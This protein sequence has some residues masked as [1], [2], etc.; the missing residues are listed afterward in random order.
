[1]VELKKDWNEADFA[2][3][4]KVIR[5]FLK[6]RKFDTNEKNDAFRSIST[7]KQID[8]IIGLAYTSS[9]A[10]TA[11]YVCSVELYLDADH[12]YKIRGFVIGTDGY[13]YAF[14]E[15]E[16]DNELYLMI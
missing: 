1:M 7:F 12:K 11:L 13:F 9:S 3:S 14:C 2:A 5:R 15:D 4:A 16:N 10:I 6:S 8:E